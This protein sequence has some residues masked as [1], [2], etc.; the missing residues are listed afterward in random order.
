MKIKISINI[1]SYENLELESNEHDNILS[2]HDDIKIMINF[3]AVYLHKVLQYKKIF[4]K[5]GK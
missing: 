4:D 3:Y 2:C 5:E 1:A